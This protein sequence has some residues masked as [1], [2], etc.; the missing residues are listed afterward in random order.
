MLKVRGFE[1]VSIEIEGNFGVKTSL[2][3][4]NLITNLAQF[5][6]A[7]QLFQFLMNKDKFRRK[8]C[9]DVMTIPRAQ[10]RWSTVNKTKPIRT[11]VCLKAHLHRKV[12]HMCCL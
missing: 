10:K 5:S 4:Q 3:G 9:V 12:M 1:R 7:Y 6:W 11:V 2:R 8:M